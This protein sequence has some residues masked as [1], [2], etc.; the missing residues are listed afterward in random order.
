MCKEDTLQAPRSAARR[1]RSQSETAVK[2]ETAMKTP[3]KKKAKPTDKVWQ[4]YGGR[5]EG[6]V[7]S[8]LI[9]V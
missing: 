7:R 6:Y 8:I 5:D 9:S 4:D 3:S 2:E 1:K